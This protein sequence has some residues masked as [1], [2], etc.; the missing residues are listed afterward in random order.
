[1]TI[2]DTV[3]FPFFLYYRFPSQNIE[4]FEEDLLPSLHLQN[5]SNIENMKINVQL[6]KDKH[7]ISIK[8]N[9]IQNITFD[10]SMGSAIMK[11][12]VNLFR[13]SI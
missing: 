13:S 5:T 10:S 12:S 6:I 4:G 7:I 2:L 1:M 3:P 11:C 9:I 8:N